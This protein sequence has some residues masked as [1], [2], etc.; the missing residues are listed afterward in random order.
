M[1]AQQVYNENLGTIRRIAAFEARRNQLHPEEAEDF[2]QEVCKRLLEDDYAII[3]K[4][5][6]RS[7]F[8]TYLTTVIGH[9]FHEVRVKL[10]GKWRPS[11]EA[12][13]IGDKAITL[14]RMITRDGYTFSEAVKVLT[15][16]AGSQ[17]TIAEL[18]VIYTRL[19][20]RNPRPVIISDDVV[21]D[22][23][24]VNSEADGRVEMGERERAAR[25]TAIAIDEAL[26]A[27]DGE[28][29]LLLQLRFWDGRKVPDIAQLLHSDQKKLYKR[30]DRLF[31][32]LRRALETA[33]VTRSDIDT[34]L[35]SGDQEIT[36]DL[37]SATEIPPSG[38][39][40][41]RGGGGSR[42]GEE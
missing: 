2:V 28:D 15:T 20:P 6:G 36:L 7:Q 12:K 14:E 1:D 13:R 9:L 34:L 40:N 32:L 17:Y 18:E 39:S 10:W 33:G 41:K 19:P 16:P 37:V 23:L 5:E 27:M 26:A 24:A 8:S 29:R 25:Q 22:A 31:L 38:P 4:F 42:G 30:L 3:R 11:A 35:V 21:P